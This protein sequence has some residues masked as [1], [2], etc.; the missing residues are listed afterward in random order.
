MS[1]R[2]GCNLVAAVSAA[3]LATFD[4]TA[5]LLDFVP[6]SQAGRVSNLFRRRFHMT[7]FAEVDE[8]STGCGRPVC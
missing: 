2:D 1:K 3:N 6:E 7:R 5:I 4:N 8:D